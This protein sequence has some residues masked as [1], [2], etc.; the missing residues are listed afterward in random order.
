MADFGIS[1]TAALYIAMAATVAT[2]AGSAA[3]QYQQQQKA[4][5]DQNTFNTAQANNVRDATIENYKQAG[6]QIAQHNDEAENQLQ[7][8]ERA[9]RDA[10]ASAMASAAQNNVTGNSVSALAQEYDSRAG[11]FASDV[12][13]NRNAADN[14]IQLQ[15]QGFNT[16]AQGQINSLRPATGPSLLTPALQ[17]GG[18]AASAYATYDSRQLA[19]EKADAFRGA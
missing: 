14:E 10:E 1:E 16:S 5:H 6:T 3:M 11:S 9:S 8:N 13:Y 2:A 17:I 12:T 4:A 18:A 19:S 15:M 7:Q